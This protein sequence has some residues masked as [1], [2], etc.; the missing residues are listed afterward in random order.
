MQ[1]AEG[2]ATGSKGLLRSPAFRSDKVRRHLFLERVHRL[3][4]VVVITV[5]PALTPAASSAAGPLKSASLT[6]ATHQEVGNVFVYMGTTPWV[7]MSVDM[8]SGDAFVTCEVVGENGQVTVIGS[9]QL[10]D[11]YGSWGSQD[12]GSLGT[13]SGARLVAANGTVL[14]S[15]T[16]R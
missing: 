3:S 9:F 10:S 14:A 2:P 15:A 4:D 13:V 1:S 5:P 8:G 11:G 12:P 6:S 16:F 7:Y